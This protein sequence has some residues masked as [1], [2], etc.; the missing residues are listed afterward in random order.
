MSSYRNYYDSSYGRSRTDSTSKN[1]PET[2]STPSRIAQRYGGSYTSSL[3]T[4]PTPGRAESRIKSDSLHPPVSYKS[5]LPR[6]GTR[7]RDPSPSVDKSDRTSA[8]SNYLSPNRLYPRPYTR[9]NTSRESTISPTG[10]V[11]NLPRLGKRD[12]STSGTLSKFERRSPLSKESSRSPSVSK[13]E[14]LSSR[15]KS[16]R[17]DISGGSQKYLNS[18]FLPK[19]SVERSYTAYTRPSTVRTHEVS[20]KNKELLGVLHAQHEQEK[21]S[22]RPAS[23]CSSVSREDSVKKPSPEREKN[24]NVE[25]VTVKV[26]TR[27]T[28]PTLGTSTQHSFLRSRRIEVAK[29]I[30]KTVTRPKCNKENMVDKEMQSDRLDDSTR[31]SRFA[32]ASR[33]NATPW[34]SFLDMKFSSPNN[35]KGDRS[36]PDS[37]ES[38]KSLSRTSSTRSISSEKDSKKVTKSK[39]T[40]PKQISDKKQL[41]PPI[42]KS[43]S[44]GKGSLHSLNTPNKDF[45]KSVLNM[46]PDG[47]KK[48]IG[49]RSNS[50][51]S[52]DSD[53]ADPDATDISEN[54]T[55]CRS[56]HKSSSGSKLPQ[57]F[58]G[59]KQRGRRSP[60]SDVSVSST[61]G[62]SSSEDDNKK[63]K[64]KIRSTSSSRTSMVLTTGDE[65]PS[66]R[67]SKSTGIKQKTDGTRTETDAKKFLMRALA[68]V[69][70]LFKANKN[71]VNVEPVSDN[72]TDVV[73]H[74]EK[75]TWILDPSSDSTGEK[76]NAV[77]GIQSEP[78]C[79]KLILHRVECTD[80]NGWWGDRSETTTDN[81]EL[82]QVSEPINMKYNDSSKV[83]KPI[84]IKQNLSGET[85][86]WLDPNQSAPEG[87]TTYSDSIKPPFKHADSGEKAWW[88]E[89]ENSATTDDNQTYSNWRP[90]EPTNQQ[91]DQVNIQKPIM[92]PVQ[93]GESPWWLEENNPQAPEGVFIYPSQVQEQ[94]E[95]QQQVNK[96]KIRPVD[97]G[98]IAWWM[99][100][101]GT[102][103]E[104]V[105][106][107]SPNVSS[108]QPPELKPKLR[109][110]DSGEAPWWL[111]KEASPPE[112]IQTYSNWSSEQSNS[113]KLPR[114]DSGNATWWQ[115]NPKSTSDSTTA[116]SKDNNKFTPTEFP[117]RHQLRHIDSGERAWWLNDDD[118]PADTTEEPLPRPKFPITHQDSGERTWWMRENQDFDNQEVPLGDRASPEG[119][120][121]PKD[122]EGRLS[123]YDNV[124][125]L[126]E[127]E[128]KRAPSMF[129]S[130][131]QNIDDILGGVGQSWCHFTNNFFGY[132]DDGEEYKE[133][134]AKEVIIHEG[135]GKK[136]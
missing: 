66:D 34:S 65:L 113:S 87:V 90:Q 32:G 16:S 22:S 5:T 40:P 91:T 78:K 133:I 50:A 102:P 60:S 25:M 8:S 122:T 129:I 84:I 92:R 52:A 45:R 20:R 110:V 131:H 130:K 98:E 107:W 96:A 55:S 81:S 30:E 135:N 76:T 97:S 7:S 59:D 134:D 28:S 47:S 82:K 67:S 83:P 51:S 10:S 85:A 1:L 21:L 69:T 118:A 136:G 18:R 4:T 73:D 23:R 24:Q 43:E 116:A 37:V 62:P 89:D 108:E 72:Q 94:Q 11:S 124:P 64:N 127:S 12:D 61:T 105:Q 121:M 115:E 68:P 42:P 39:L 38:P 123:P 41:P 106:N 128:K 114:N 101:D 27:G 126:R 100:K 111:N 70:N 80:P 31:S 103:P 33:I 74:Q 95:T 132:G 104:G 15:Y 44:S 58:S 49:R 29:T 109:T 86:W 71:H 79:A 14:S 3:A 35:K 19:N 48:R 53:N 13:E 99:K 6:P 77:Q 56:Y 54:L 119:L 46:N 26:C 17:E 120:E 2:R 88:L 36:K 93:S 117:E 57:K 112:G 125:S 75:V 9:S 63:V